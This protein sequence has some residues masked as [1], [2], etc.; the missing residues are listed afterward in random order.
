MIFRRPSDAFKRPLQTVLI[1]PFRPPSDG[2][3][4]YSYTTYR[5]GAGR[6]ALLRA[7]LRASRLRRVGDMS[8]ARFHSDDGF[9]SPIRSRNTASFLNALALV[10]NTA[11]DLLSVDK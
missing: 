9:S 7:V 4:T 1:P 8:A 6:P 5:A 10:I 2:L 3:Q 11:T